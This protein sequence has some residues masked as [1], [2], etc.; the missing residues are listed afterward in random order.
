MSEA[1][2]KSASE[3]SGPKEKSEPDALIKEED[4]QPGSKITKESPEKSSEEKMDSTDDLDDIIT[5]ER[6]NKFAT[7][8]D[9][10]CWKCHREYINI[11]CG[12]CER[13]YHF[14][15]LPSDSSL[16]TGATVSN[17]PKKLLTSKVDYSKS[18]PYNKTPWTCT[19]CV[20]IKE[21]ELFHN[22]PSSPTSS[23]TTEKFEHLL[24]FA[25]GTIKQTAEPS[26]H[27]PVDLIQFPLYK[28][29]ILHPMDFSTIEKNIRKGSYKCTASFLADIKWILHNCYIYNDPTHILTKN[30]NLFWKVAKNETSEIEI[31]PGCFEN[32]YV[33]RDNSFTYT[34][35]QF[36]TLV[37]ARLKGH[38]FWPAKV[39]RI[40][41]DTEKVDC[42]FFGAHD[43]AW[44]AFDAVFLISED[45]P[46]PKNKGSKSK[47]DNA[48][49]EM[50]LYI[51]N[52]REK[53]ADTFKYSPSKTPF[54]PDPPVGWTPKV[55][56]PVESKTA[57]D[58]SAKNIPGKG[59]D[60]KEI[61]A[62]GPKVSDASS[63]DEDE[64]PLVIDAPPSETAPVKGKSRAAAAAAATK[65]TKVA[66]TSGAKTPA[67]KVNSAESGKKTVKTPAASASTSK[68]TN[69]RSAAASGLTSNDSPGSKKR[70]SSIDETIN[71]TATGTANSSGLLGESVDE[72]TGKSA[73]SSIANQ[74]AASKK[75]ATVSISEETVAKRKPSI[76]KKTAV[77]PKSKNAQQ[78]ASPATGR[79]RGN[80]KKTNETDTMEDDSMGKTSPL[81][82]VSKDK[83]NCTPAGDLS[84]R[85]DKK[86]VTSTPATTA[87]ASK[88]G[89]GAPV[90]SS[91]GKT[92]TPAELPSESSSESDEETE[93]VDEDISS[94]KKKKGATNKKQ[95]PRALATASN[96]A[97]ASLAKKSPGKKASTAVVSNKSSTT[98]SSSNNH[99]GAP[100]ESVQVKT[101]KEEIK[102]LKKQISSLKDE[103]KKAKESTASSTSSSSAS[104]KVDTSV[105]EAVINETK[106]KQWCAG[107]LREAQYF[108]CWNTSY[109][110]YECQS[111]HW[112]EHMLVCQNQQQQ[113]NHANNNASGNTNTAT[114]SSSASKSA[115]RNAK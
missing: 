17:L 110:S 99:S 97:T 90:K 78:N 89:K 34:C 80:K 29:F 22:A 41:F 69:K 60:D 38:P 111:K 83:S 87:G 104:V 19:Q 52:V 55:P 31:C 48:V 93:Q 107:C 37:W 5:R 8:K 30:A 11:S 86:K 94:G 96:Q 72:T 32:F 7:G 106:R 50:E 74:R 79:A 53:F 105:S 46:W 102:S 61:S 49:K 33:F 26:F 68:T 88:S 56:Q 112:P 103:L 51:K 81:T 39:F 28:D 100:S 98:Q 113:A 114:N 85:K 115:S 44:V 25:L 40:D 42:R 57:E 35:S 18:P 76:S 43:R 45:Y 95:S 2:T 73:T 47:L 62:T 13:S 70:K 27:T 6:S 14:K 75:A 77:S 23:I 101:L 10:Y 84:K 82:S 15:C 36:H 71:S 16:P 65:V 4:N 9:Y 3:E 20:I 64:K 1:S 54:K 63:E 58:K 21:N 12:H 24:K 108:C 67:A 59:V 91:A 66:V 92:L 109:C